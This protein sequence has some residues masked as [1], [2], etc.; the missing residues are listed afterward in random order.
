MSMM[1]LLVNLIEHRN[2]S[3]ACSEKISQLI[4][5]HTNSLI[6]CF[7][8]SFKFNIFN[9]ENIGNCK[10]LEIFPSRDIVIFHIFV[11]LVVKFITK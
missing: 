1:N 5:E 8:T 3:H 9:S 7:S 4:F 6:K 10:F 11:K 2:Y